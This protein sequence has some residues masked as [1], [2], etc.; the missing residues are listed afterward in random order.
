M[1]RDDVNA[2]TALSTNPFKKGGPLNSNFNNSLISEGTKKPPTRSALR[3][4]AAA[5]N[6][7]SRESAL[8]SQTQERMATRGSFF[9]R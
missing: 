4:A 6:D 5:S 9:Q 3:R 8:N 7:T 1:G 2:A